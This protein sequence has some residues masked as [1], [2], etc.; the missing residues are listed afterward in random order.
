MRGNEVKGR[1]SPNLTKANQIS[2]ESLII[3]EN[4]HENLL[5]YLN[6]RKRGELFGG[7]DSCSAC[8][9]QTKEGFTLVTKRTKLK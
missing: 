9:V 4:M 5:I 7:E 6:T 8:T 3:H 1:K 2:I